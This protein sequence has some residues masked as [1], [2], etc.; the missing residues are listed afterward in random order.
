[1]RPF[2]LTIVFAFSWIFVSSAQER[3]Q[4]LFR[5]V[6]TESKRPVPYATIQFANNKNGVI[7]NIKGDFRIPIRYKKESNIF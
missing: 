4:V 6:D 1:M 2:Y 3:Q 5:V 7:A